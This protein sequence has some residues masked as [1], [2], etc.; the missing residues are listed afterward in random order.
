MEVAGFDSLLEPS[1]RL[2]A[3]PSCPSSMKGPQFSISWQRFTVSELSAS[4]RD[5]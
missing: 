1:S 3:I 2:Q 4:L 5:F